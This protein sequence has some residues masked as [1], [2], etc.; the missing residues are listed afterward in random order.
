MS[1]GEMND[2]RIRRRGWQERGRRRRPVGHVAPILPAVLGAIGLV[3]AAPAAMAEAGWTDYALVTE[4]TPTIHQR[5]EVT[6]AVQQNPSGCR[7]K[8]VFFQDYSAKG[9]EQMYL[10]LLESVGSG[11][12]VRVFVNGECGV[13]GYSRITAVGIRP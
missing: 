5:Y 9:S 4:L 10:A 3:A 6:I 1:T 11:K 2:E 12:R 8:Q 13:N 7:E